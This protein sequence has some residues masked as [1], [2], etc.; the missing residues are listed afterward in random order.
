VLTALTVLGLTLASTG[1]AGADADTVAAKGDAVT[2]VVHDSFPVEAFELAAS[3]ATGLDVTVL[4]SGD[5]GE[6]A[7]KLVLTKGAPIADAFYG[8]DNALVSR[9]VDTDVVEPYAAILPE[10]AAGFAY[11]AA[12][13]VTPIDHGF[14]CV[15]I[16]TGW[17]EERGVPAPVSYQ[18]L[19]RPEYQNLTVL[20]D[21]TSSSTGASF[22]VGTVAHFGEN[23]F[24]DYWKDLFKNGAT[25]AQGWTEGYNGEFT[26]GGESGTKPIVV[27]YSTSPAWTVTEDG[28][29]STTSSL[30]ET[31]STQI[32][33]AGVLA[34]AQNPEGARALVDYLLSS[35]FQATIA[36]T[37]YIYPVDQTVTLPTE[38]ERFAA[39]PQ[40][41]N[42]L[43]AATIGAERENWLRAWSEGTGY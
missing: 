24:V 16:D 18:D 28:S 5:G 37:M 36:D 4:T 26:Q 19:V 34:G 30:P 22:L 15:N 33:Y 20:L 40:A 35:E 2:I 32:E 6:L 3:A 29:A 43:P 9:L 21:P 38:W 41:P 7:N 11:D 31:C 42:D 1:C 14:T 39:P 8:V 25:L 10:G 13:S 27:S 12:G 17:F 23:G